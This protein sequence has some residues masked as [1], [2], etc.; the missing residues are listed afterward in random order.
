MGYKFVYDQSHPNPI[1]NRL[2]LV[3]TLDENAI[4][5]ITVG[6]R[7]M[8]TGFCFVIQLLL[9]VEGFFTLVSYFF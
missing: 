1:S 3:I 8:T 5:D 9:L 6:G 7:A 2:N 4:T